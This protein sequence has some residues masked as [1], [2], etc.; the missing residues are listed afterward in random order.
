MQRIA[1]LSFVLFA[2]CGG[3]TETGEASLSMS[4]PPAKSAAAKPFS[5][6]DGAGNTVLG[7]K[8]ELYADGPGADCLSEDIQKVA[9]VG[10]YTKKTSAD[11]PQA[12]LSVG[13]IAIVTQAPPTVVGETAANFSMDGVQITGGLV[14]ITEFHLTADAKHADRIAGTISAGGTTG[15]G[16]VSVD[17]TFTA[18][19]CVED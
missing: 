14:S 2:A 8:I 9:T 15:T 4:D 5:G 13:G 19:V 10:I 3:G 1:C 11:G 7:W 12:L 6:M 16:D 17:G 18:P